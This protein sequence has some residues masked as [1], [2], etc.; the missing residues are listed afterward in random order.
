M[1][2][3]ARAPPI[4]VDTRRVVIDQSQPDPNEPTVRKATKP[5]PMLAVQKDPGKR[6]LIESPVRRRRAPPS[7]TSSK[8][9]DTDASADLE[10]IESESME[11]EIIILDE[12]EEFE[13]KTS[14]PHLEQTVSK[15]PTLR[16]L[17]QLLLYGVPAVMR[18]TRRRST[19][20]LTAL[21][22]HQLEQMYYTMLATV[23]LVRQL[24][25]MTE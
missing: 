12:P 19:R 4:Q 8:S 22:E 10:I 18:E 14:L 3:P 15:V 23:P 7:Q 11:P 2:P 16:T 13:C 5:A 1:K 24:D 6:K 17:R 25:S 21:E 9:I 20:P